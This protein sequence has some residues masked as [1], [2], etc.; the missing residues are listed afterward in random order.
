MLDALTGW[1]AAANSRPFK[2]TDGGAS[3]VVQT[4]L[5]FYQNDDIFFSSL[6]RG[7]LIES[8]KVYRTTNGGS[9]IF[10]QSEMVSLKLRIPVV[11]G[12]KLQNCGKLVLETFLHSTVG[13]AMPQENWA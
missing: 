5:P 4:N 3:W 8:M 13:L 9:V 6:Q 2:T 11:P 1:L 12:M 7:F 10:L